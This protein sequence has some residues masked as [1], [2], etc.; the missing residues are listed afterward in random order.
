MQFR[1]FGGMCS[2]SASFMLRL[3]T[4]QSWKWRWCVPLNHQ[5]PSKLHG[6]ATRKTGLFI[7]IKTPNP[8]CQQILVPWKSGK[9]VSICYNVCRWTDTI[10]LRCIIFCNISL[11][12]SPSQKKK[13]WERWNYILLYEQKDCGNR[14]TPGPSSSHEW[15]NYLDISYSLCSRENVHPLA[16]LA[17]KEAG[18]PHYCIL[19]L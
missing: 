11:L 9:W 3:L 14:W 16:Q 12:T 4:I 15:S 1:Y 5:A 13:E 19:C 7:V 18:Y 10:K 8:T 6:T 2:A 17:R